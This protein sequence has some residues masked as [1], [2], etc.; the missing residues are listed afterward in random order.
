MVKQ[1][2]LPQLI[3]MIRSLIGQARGIVFPFTTLTIEI[4]H[5]EDAGDSEI[6]EG[7]CAYFTPRTCPHLKAVSAH[8]T[9]YML[10]NYIVDN[11]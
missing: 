10:K 8:F 9:S 2:E 1:E 4:D 7:T 3:S 6:V 5:I 11:S